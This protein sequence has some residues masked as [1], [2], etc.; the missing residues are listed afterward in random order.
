[1]GKREDI[2]KAAAE[3]FAAKGYAGTSFGTI[4]A[5]VGMHRN[6]LQHYIS[7]KPE[8]AAEIAWAPFLDGQF[9]A[10][11]AGDIE[12]IAGML[13]MARQIADTYAADVTARASM[14]LIEQSANIPAE[15]PKPF[16]GWMGPSEDLLRQAVNRGEIAK[17]ADLKDLAWRLVSAFVG[18]RVVSDVLG[19]LDQFPDRVVRTLDDIMSVYRPKSD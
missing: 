10:Q 3:E 4:A 1:M 5:R 9:L 19:E 16:V 7:S 8:L 13:A 2:L 11:P 17:D 6:A 15:L 18:V 14:R 12:G